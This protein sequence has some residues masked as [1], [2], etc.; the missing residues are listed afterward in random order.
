MGKRI[1]HVDRDA[2]Q[3]QVF[4][5]EPHLFDQRMRDLDEVRASKRVAHPGQ[6]VYDRAGVCQGVRRT[7]RSELALEPADGIN[8][9]ANGSLSGFRVSPGGG[10][11]SWLKAR[12]C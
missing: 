3:L 12:R 4:A 8:E 9:I 2:K 10:P 11:P 5:V 7:D 6:Q 1:E